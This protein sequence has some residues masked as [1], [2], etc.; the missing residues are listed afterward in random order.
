MLIMAKGNCNGQN[1]NAGACRMHGV[2]YWVFMDKVFLG[3]VF[4]NFAVACISKILYCRL[5]AETDNTFWTV[6]KTMA[7]DL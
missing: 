2:R 5:F 4:K 7:V 3:V 6:R 1:R